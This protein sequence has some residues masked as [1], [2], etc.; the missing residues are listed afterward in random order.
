MWLCQR[1]IERWSSIGTKGLFDEGS[2]GQTLLNQLASWS[3][4]PASSS[5][6]LY[7]HDASV[8][9]ELHV[10]RQ[11]LFK[12]RQAGERAKP[13]SWQLAQC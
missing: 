13:P 5:L 4:T 1:L 2:L 12:G 6:T 10:L 11:H 3:G 8:E 7:R 9:R